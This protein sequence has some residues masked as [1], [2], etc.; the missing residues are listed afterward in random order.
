MVKKEKISAYQLFWL[1]V[2]LILGDAVIISPGGSCGRDA[3]I[4]IIISTLGGL[5]L[6]SIYGYIA[7]LHR[8][9]TLIEILRVTFGNFLGNIFGVLYIWYFVHI[10]SLIAR[11]YG[12]YLVITNYSETP[13]VALS[14]F[15]MVLIG[16]L[17]KKGIEVAGRLG[18]LAIPITLIFT[19]ILTIFTIQEMEVSNIKPFFE[20]GFLPVL[21]TSYRL[22]TFPFGET[23]VLLMIFPFLNKKSNPIKVSLL[24]T[25][26]VGMFFLLIS[27]RNVF[28]LGAS[29]MSKITFTN[30]T[31][32][33]L[34]Q[35]AVFDPFLSISLVIVAIFQAGL[36]TFGATLGLCQLF[37]LGNYRVF[38][39]PVIG[40]IITLSEWLYQ[41]FQQIGLH[42]NEIYPYYAIP[43]QFI[44]PFLILIISLFKA[45]RKD[46]KCYNLK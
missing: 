35:S 31:I 33:T 22:L 37:K 18:E 44:I 36:F 2:A 26:L 30:H 41:N 38:I 46:K 21:K 25:S 45:K 5:I 3:W 32:S 39:F 7:I 27:I 24:A 34:I 20:N 15:L 8:D 43:F 9:K 19:I 4:A 12:E 11:S 16:Y 29:V 42:A 6:V 10:A 23:V 17:L 40:I 28:V 13:R 1:I 14:L